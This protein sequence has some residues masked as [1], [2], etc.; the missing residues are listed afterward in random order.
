MLQEKYGQPRMPNTM[1][2]ALKNESEIK[3]PLRSPKKKEKLR[4]GKMFTSMHLIYHR[5]GREQEEWC[6][7]FLR[8]IGSSTVI[9]FEG[10]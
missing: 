5:K 10:R 4:R 8:Y 7:R 3:N 6:S 1:N 2:I 9:L